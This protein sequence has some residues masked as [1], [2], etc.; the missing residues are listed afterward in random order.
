MRCLNN[1]N[2][3]LFYKTARIRKMYLSNEKFYF[4]RDRKQLSLHIFLTGLEKMDIFH[5]GIANFN[6]KDFLES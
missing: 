6:E 1:I 5:A 2:N 3:K 4:F